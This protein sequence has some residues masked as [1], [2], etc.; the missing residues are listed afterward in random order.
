MEK[1]QKEKYF[2]CSTKNSSDERIVSFDVIRIFAIFAV[3]MIH[4][5]APLIN[6][7]GGVYISKYF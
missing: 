5:A 2:L 1:V 3:I 6:L 4:I 7:G